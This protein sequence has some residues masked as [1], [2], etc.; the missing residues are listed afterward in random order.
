MLHC[1]AEDLAYEVVD[2]VPRLFP[3]SEVERARQV[4]SSF[5]AWWD[6]AGPR[7]TRERARA[8]RAVA[9]LAG[10]GRGRVACDAGAGDGRL[11]EV[12]A[13]DGWNAYALDLEIPP[14]RDESVHW[15]AGMLEHPPF[16]PAT[17]D[18]VV[19]SG[20][21]QYVSD[22]RVLSRWRT[23][24]R[25]EGRIVVVL[26]PLHRTEDA[27]RRDER[28]ARRRIQHVVQASGLVDRYRHFTRDEIVR[29]AG[30]CGLQATFLGS[31]LGI[32]LRAYRAVKSLAV[33]GDIARFPLL[34]LSHATRPEFA[35]H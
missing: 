1:K 16:A 26:T 31:P 6:V 32:P 27:A 11:A 29:A 28:E 14:R 34:V 10:P 18:L 30:G 17:L 3:P 35:A 24:L 22:L 15:L 12:L 5:S 21:L 7:Y 20:S 33:G 4:H 13:A 25:A 19:M 2:G 8:R 9:R 23:S